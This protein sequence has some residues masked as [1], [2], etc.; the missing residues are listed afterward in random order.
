MPTSHPVLSVVVPMYDEEDVLPIFFERM[1]PLL[2]GLGISYEVLVVDD[3]SRDGTATLLREATGTWPQLRLVRLLRN[4]GHQAALSAGFRRARGDY[5][6]TIDADLQDPPEAIAE[7]LATAREKDVDVVYGVRSDRS[8]DSWPKRT[9][10]RMYYRLMCRLVGM[11]I[12]F[13]A[14]DFRLV[15]RRVVDAVNGLPEDGRVFRLVIPWLGFPSAQVKYVRAERAAGVTKYNWSKMFRLAFDSVTAFSAAPLRLA[16]WL[17]LLGG[18]VCGLFVVGALVVKL[19]GNSVPGWTSTVLAVGIIGAIQ[20]LCLGLL[21]E[22]VARLFQS[23]QRR[24]QFLVGY[25]SLEDPGHHSYA[26]AIDGQS[27][28]QR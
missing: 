4:S 13:D 12:P 28:E 10:A 23:S 26:E 14:G 25:D 6:V 19:S 5:L 16:T 9:T 8:S 20:L 24:P 3:G 7:L 17:G 11:D 15:S 2:D 27:P 21:G 22:Y 1:H 18:L